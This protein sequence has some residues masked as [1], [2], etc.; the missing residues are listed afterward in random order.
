M[1]AHQRALLTASSSL[2]SASGKVATVAPTFG[3]VLELFAFLV[4]LC[5]AGAFTKLKMTSLVRGAARAPR[6]APSATR[7]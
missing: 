4:T 7:R 3:A 2:V 5:A 1:A 6:G